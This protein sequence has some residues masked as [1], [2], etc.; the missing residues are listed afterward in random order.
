MSLLSLDGIM[1]PSLDL[2]LVTHW[3]RIPASA[4]GL[5]SYLTLRTSEIQTDQS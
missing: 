2:K 4:C 5:T 1:R 3:S